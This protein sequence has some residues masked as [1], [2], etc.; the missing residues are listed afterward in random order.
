MKSFS[1]S[2]FGNFIAIYDLLFISLWVIIFGLLFICQYFCFVF[3]ANLQLQSTA[4]SSHEDQEQPPVETDRLMPTG[5]SIVLSNGNVHVMYSTP[6]RNGSPVVIE[7]Q[8]SSSQ[9]SYRTNGSTT[10]GRSNKS[11]EITQY[12]RNMLLSIGT[13]G[14]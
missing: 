3:T 5:G 10:S 12:D 6:P 11:G 13:L 1:L 2:G 7:T 8:G 14:E 9:K 4:G